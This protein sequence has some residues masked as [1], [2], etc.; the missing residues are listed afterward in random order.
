M[1]IREEPRRAGDPPTLVADISRTVEE[2]EWQPE[3][4]TIDNIVR[5]AVQWY[6]KMNQKEIN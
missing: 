2:L 3:H 1:N 6:N 4:S 5:T